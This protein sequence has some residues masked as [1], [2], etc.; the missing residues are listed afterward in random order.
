MLILIS[1]VFGAQTVELY[2]NA[3]PQYIEADRNIT[4]TISIVNGTNRS[5]TVT[6]YDNMEDGLFSDSDIT[7]IDNGG[8]TCTVDTS[9][10]T[11]E[12]ICSNIII[13][14]GA[15]ATIRYTIL[16]PDAPMQITN[17][18]SITDNNDNN[19]LLD[20][21]SVTV[22]ILPNYEGDLGYERDLCYLP[23][24]QEDTCLQSGAFFY[25]E[26]CNT[27]VTIVQQSDQELKN[28]HVFKSYTSAI[29][30][31]ACYTQESGV[32]CGIEK[33][34]DLLLNRDSSSY[35]KLAFE[36]AHDF[37]LG[38]L[39]PDENRTLVDIN[40]RPVSTDRRDP[41][42][43]F[44]YIALVGQYNYDS[45]DNT[46]D[47]IEEY[48]YPCDGIYSGASL[49]QRTY[50]GINDVDLVNVD[51]TAN[52]AATYIPYANYNKVG[53]KIVNQPFILGV[54]YLDG[55]G[56]PATYDGTF[57]DQPVRTIN[58]PVILQYRGVGETEFKPLWAG[59]LPSGSDHI[60]TI[61]SNLNDA[62]NQN[63]YP[64]IDEALRAAEISIELIDYGSFF[65][66]I[67]GLRCAV[68]SLESSLCLVPACLNSETQ[69]LG[70][71]PLETYPHVATCLY[72]D[73][74]GASPCDGN[75]YY[76]NCGGKK[77]TISPAKYNNDYGCAQ[78]LADAVAPEVIYNSFSIRPKDFPLNVPAWKDDLD[79]KVYQAGRDYPIDLNA[80][81]G[82]GNP[83]N[84][85]EEDNTTRSTGYNTS[86]Q[87]YNPPEVLAVIGLE[88]NAS[89]TCP[90]E[91]NE[92]QTITFVNGYS[93]SP[94]NYHN[95]GKVK[96]VI[97]DQ[98]W[99]RVDQ[100]ISSP[101]NSTCI[102]DSKET[103]PTLD[104]LNR[105]RVGCMLIT[106]KSMIFV[107]DHFN[108]DA[109]LTDHNNLRNF[110]YL[111]DI[112]AYDTDDNYTMGAQL[113][114]DIKAMGADNNVTSNYMETCYAKE[115]NLTLVLDSTNIIY[116]GPIQAL[117]HFLYYNPT[118]DNGTVNSGEGNYSLP[119]AV[120]NTISLPSLPIDNAPSTF[121]ADA[122]EGN[123]TSHIEYKL[124]FDRKQN[125]AVNPF[126]LNLSDVN[127]TDEDEVETVVLNL[128]DRNATYYYARSRASQFFYEDIT[129]ANASTPILIDVY[130][131]PFVVTCT[132]FGIDTVNG[133]INDANWWLSLGHNETTYN[134]GNIT[135]IINLPGAIIEG[136]NADTP[137]VDTDVTVDTQAQDATITVRSNASQL[138]M[139]VLIDLDQTN[140]TDT[141]HWL[142]YNPDD[143]I[144]APSPFYKV[145]FIGD[146]SWTGE[147]QTGYIVD[148]NASLKKH[149]KMDW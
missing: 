63:P 31:D 126:N 147:G 26:D 81:T 87:G 88:S 98:N 105:G 82:T 53:T 110:T 148:V 20:E 62:A 50:G 7:I 144:L 38:D 143:A 52:N 76:G 54:T 68:S 115:T 104:P 22:T 134:D 8:F 128:I 70:V 64:I 55:D 125:L 71:F 86:L 92:S 69:I 14:S 3:S 112:N 1:S 93:S 139:T 43:S 42:T 13:P 41:V 77:T 36:E 129:E 140:P 4:Y 120:N 94:I 101:S 2:K 136:N 57:G 78:C 118:E 23:P 66:E 97:M 99:T 49:T 109:N 100:N 35:F 121:P 21:A 108:I 40:T 72:G 103:N 117:T 27:T 10:L 33:D 15:S 124:N 17:E 19:N 138:P 16:A 48:I 135:L 80:T 44:E 111:H 73:G 29:L 51:I 146:S 91:N 107:P 133:A 96:L 56:N 122:P 119:V 142:I 18:A 61:E 84:I 114:I 46:D 83:G 145:R 67:E 89:L 6:L 113:T 28:V 74:G 60:L 123:G 37:S 58:A 65:R 59:E 102:V 127:I 32:E 131:D 47:T 39:N 45:D 24:T 116:P 137:T 85:A 34:L 25:G 132:D 149:K 141:N 12:L 5:K 75:A 9:N 95:V 130:C 30:S 90:D 11:N 79:P 106:E